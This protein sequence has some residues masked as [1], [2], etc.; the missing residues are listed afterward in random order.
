MAKGVI[1]TDLEL[2]KDYGDVVGIY[3]GHLPCLLVADPEVIKEICIKQFH[4]FTNRPMPF[5][6]D[7]KYLYS[8]AI[9]T[10]NHWKFLRSTLSPTFTSGKMKTMMPKI[11]KCCDALVDNIGLQCNNHES[12]EMKELCGAYT[13]DVICSTAFGIEVD[14]QKDPNNKFVHYAKMAAIGSVT[15][16]ILMFA[17]MFPF[18]N[19]FMKIEMVKKEVYD[20][21]LSATRSTLDMRKTSKEEYHDFL[22][23]M[24]DA[25]Q[26]GTSTDDFTA[27]ELQEFKDRGLNERE[28]EANAR[29]FFIAGYDT[30]A[31]TLSFACYC[32]ATNPDVQQKV[33]AEIDSEL[34]G[35][36][37]QFDNIGKLEYMDRF[38]NEVLRL[39]GAATRFNR[40]CKED[41]TI[42]GIFI[43]KGMDVNVPVCAVHR[44]PKYWPDPEKFDPERFTEYNKAKRPDYAFIPF[45]VGPRMCIGMRLAVLEAKMALIYMLRNYKFSV[46]E[47]TEVPVIF[48]KGGLLRAKNGIHVMVDKR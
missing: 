46:C 11:Q 17:M 37:P 5:K 24:I 32:L 38:L 18:L 35:K 21:F 4:N 2:H 10:D 19:R 16:P 14:S 41:T 34:Q 36:I 43:P 27:G 23:L 26:S 48:E 3:H 20:F 45:G 30:T 12:V 15:R 42:K 7:K 8:L 31:N 25:R 13:M 33:I 28:I 6:I 9:T 39:Y 22:Q 29:S 44:N 1:G 40:H 47:K